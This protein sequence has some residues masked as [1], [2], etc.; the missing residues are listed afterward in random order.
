M[1]TC[2]RAFSNQSHVLK[3]ISIIVA[4]DFM[5]AFE[6]GQQELVD[7]HHYTFLIDICSIM[8]QVDA[9]LL[10]RVH[11]VN[12]ILADHIFFSTQKRNNYDKFVTTGNS[13]AVLEFVMLLFIGF[14]CANKQT[15][16]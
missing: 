9:A 12:H 2:T 15:R 1:Y 8:Q 3:Q 4:L 5:P 6:V 13:F 10:D 16:V 7:I 14:C 11:A